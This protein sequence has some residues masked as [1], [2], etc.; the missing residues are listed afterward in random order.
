MPFEA[1][2]RAGID[3]SKDLKLPLYWQSPC[4]RIGRGSRA[5][6]AGA[7]DESVYQTMLKDAKLNG[8]KVRVFFTTLPFVD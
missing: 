2:Q 5:V 3:A 6:E 1:L 8:A 7:F 4:D